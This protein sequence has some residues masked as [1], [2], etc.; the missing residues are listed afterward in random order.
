MSAAMA[1]FIAAKLL[2]DASYDVVPEIEVTTGHSL[3]FRAE[4]DE[5]NVLV[6][7]TRPPAAPEPRRGRS[8]GRRPRHRR[9]QDKRPAGRTRRRRDP[10]RRLLELPGRRLVRRPGRTTRRSPSTR[11]RLPRPAERPRRGLPE[12][13]VPLE[14]N[15]AI[16]FLDLRGRHDDDGRPCFA[17]DRRCNGCEL[18]VPC[19]SPPHTCEQQ[20]SKNTANRSRS[21]R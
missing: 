3:D 8:R 19:H 20:S 18:F 16:E 2:T 12:G 5:T 14:L 6:E 9:D 7:V 1:E 11:S 10:L 15:D 21:K 17:L 13:V 4:S